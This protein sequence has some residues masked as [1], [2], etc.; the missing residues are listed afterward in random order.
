M[1]SKDNI[2]A[3][4]VAAKLTQED[5]AKL[6]GVSWATWTSWETGRNRM[7]QCF[8]ELFKIKAGQHEKYGVI[9]S[10]CKKLREQV[11]MIKRVVGEI[12]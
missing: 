3:A 1:I 4:R 8:F 11:D 9:S 6:L 10:D 12:L 7:H 5:A 2:K